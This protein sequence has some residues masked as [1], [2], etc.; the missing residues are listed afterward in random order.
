MSIPAT[1]L[2]TSLHLTLVRTEQNRCRPAKV[3]PRV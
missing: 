1:A 2:K 3:A